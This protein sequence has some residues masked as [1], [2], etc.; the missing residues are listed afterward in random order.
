MR[1]A[2]TLIELILS[3]V[4]I[5]I[6]FTVV[7]KIII[8]TNKSFASATQQDGIFNAVQLMH[9]IKNNSWDYANNELNSTDFNGTT[10]ILLVNLEDDEWNCRDRGRGTGLRVGGFLHGRNC[11]DRVFGDTNISD[12]YFEAYEDSND[13]AGGI[14]AYRDYNRSATAS[15][16]QDYDTYGLNPKVSYKD[17]NISYHYPNATA[18]VDLNYTKHDPELNTSSNMKYISLSVSFDQQ[19]QGGGCVEFDYFYP[20]IGQE[21]END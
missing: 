9:M 7:P 1:R 6:V 10:D 4:I 2:L 12:S 16:C 11:H 14:D 17:I 3:I 13:T 18:S 19:R 21:P 15:N 8:A 20:N 5:S